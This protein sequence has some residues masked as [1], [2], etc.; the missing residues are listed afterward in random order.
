MRVKVLERRFILTKLS[1]EE[2]KERKAWVY[3]INNHVERLDAEVV[4][5]RMHRWSWHCLAALRRGL[6]PPKELNLQS[7]L[8]DRASMLMLQVVLPYAL[9]LEPPW[10]LRGQPDLFRG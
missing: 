4:Q 6:P 8:L 3:G 5:A 9:Q 10:L 7:C 1:S 2:H